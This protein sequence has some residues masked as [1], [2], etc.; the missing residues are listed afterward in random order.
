MAADFASATVVFV[1]V[2][3]LRF[4]DGDVT[5]LWRLVGVDLRIAALLFGVGWVGALWYLG[6][7]PCVPDGVC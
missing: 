3:L 1:A 4:G 6:L 5:Q 2:S 7:Y